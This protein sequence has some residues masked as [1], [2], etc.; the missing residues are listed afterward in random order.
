MRTVLFRFISFRSPSL[1]YLL[2]HSRC[3]GFLFAL[4]HPQ[5]HTTVSRTPLD[6]GSARRRDLYLTIQTL[7]KRRTYMPPVGF[8]P[9]IPASARPQTHALD[10]AATGIGNAHCFVNKHTILTVFTPTTPPPRARK[11]AYR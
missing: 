8:E 9:T 6:E 4:D 1:V 3:R 11:F 5:A 7:Y 2:V 10:R